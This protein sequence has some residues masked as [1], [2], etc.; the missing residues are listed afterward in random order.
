MKALRI[1]AYILSGI[2]LLIAIPY[3]ALGFAVAV[4]GDPDVEMERLMGVSILLGVLGLGYPF[5]WLRTK[6]FVNWIVI[7]LA[8]APFCYAVAFLDA[9]VVWAV[10]GITFLC[11]GLAAADLLL[12]RK[13]RSAFGGFTWRTRL[14]VGSVLLAGVTIESV[15]VFLSSRPRPYRPPPIA[16]QGESKD[17]HQTVV[18][19]TLDTPMPKSKNVI[20]CGTL[21]LAWNHLGSD[22][23]HQPPQVQN[24]KVV[25][26][27]LNQ[28]QLTESDL[29]PNSY[30]ATAGFVKDGI[31]EKVKSEMKRRFQK[32]VQIDPM[33]RNDILAYAYLEA[34]AAFTIPFFD[35]RE[36]F[37]FRG[38][39]GKETKVSSFGI[40]E[41]H[42]YAY[43]NLRE[44]ID[45]LYFPKSEKYARAEDFAID[46][47]RGSLPNQVIVAR[48]PQKSTLS[49]TLDDLDKKCRA[50]AQ[51]PDAQ[52]LRSFGVRDVLLVPNLHWEIGHHFTEL[53]GAD[54]R[55]L[56]AGF[57][58][59]YIARAMQSI[60]FRLDRSGAE[61][62]SESKL[63]CLP[64]PTFFLCDQPFLIV[65]KKR[66]AER[67]FFVMWVDN[68]ELLCKP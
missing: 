23:L 4:L 63:Y 29:P 67:P 8:A 61:L 30:L 49:A 13:L 32:D 12:S 5:S 48:V 40:Q 46:L 51:G 26:S 62:A 53:E 18:V 44:Q 11:L 31:V 37:R 50:F 20:W 54:K 34:N 64:T 21:Q 16:F 56:N 52:Y 2:K 42:E 10:R 35:N 59:Y 17:L 39:D 9:P 28:E 33:E 7:L 65:I 3:F 14:V 66:A 1:V 38:S 57:G 15:A 22:V 25:A 27:R 41:K 6:G 68:A 24:A 36:P 43:H 58:T 47:C 55:F 45:I 60:R 19:P